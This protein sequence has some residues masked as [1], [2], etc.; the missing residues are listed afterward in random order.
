MGMF[1]RELGANAW[2]FVVHV[3]EYS[4]R[5]LSNP[6]DILEDF[7]GILRAF[8]EGPLH[9]RHCFGV[10]MMPRAPKPF[11]SW[12][13]IGGAEYAKEI[14]E[15]YHWS[16]VSGFCIRMCRTTEEPLERRPGFPTWSC[17]GYKGRVQWAFHEKA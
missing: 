3:E 5:E 4:Q 7:R 15:S 12:F 11:A 13:G 16:P 14:Y 2:E 9:I 1:P 17:S 6:A 8:E 10:P